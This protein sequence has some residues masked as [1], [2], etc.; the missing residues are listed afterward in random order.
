MKSR[1]LPRW[2]YARPV[3]TVALREDSLTHASQ[4]ASSVQ[5]FLAH[6]PF[7]FT[8]ERPGRDGATV[9]VWRDLREVYQQRNSAVPPGIHVEVDA[10]GRIVDERHHWWLR[11]W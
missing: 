1:P 8:E 4:A 9:V 7:P 11:L 6:C 3:L 2:F 10:S 5:E